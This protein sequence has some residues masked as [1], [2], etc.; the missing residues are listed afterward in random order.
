MRNLFQLLWK[1]HF[2]ILFLFFETAAGYL[3]VQN[4]NF[5]KAGFV[6]SSNTV[7]ASILSVVNDVAEYI[8]LKSTNAFLAEENAKLHALLPVALYN[9][10]NN[11]N[12]VKDTLHKQQ[13]EYIAAKV[14]N[15][16]TNKRNNYLTLNKG[17]LQGIEPEMGVICS[18][19]I[20]GIVKDVSEHYCTVMSLLHK[21]FHTSGKLTR[22]NYFGNLEWHGGNPTE[23]VIVEMPKHVPLTIGD[24]VV[25]TAYSTIFPEG[26][27][28][29]RIKNFD[30]KTG[31]NFYTIDVKLSTDFQNIDYVYIV[32]NLFREEQKQLEKNLHND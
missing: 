27:R 21:D 32:K 22:N 26:I 1:Y 8:H 6:N 2:F 4:N 16:S 29:G 31:N 19:G 24:T 5:Q 28:I 12:V 7:V 9:D 30:L 17:Q 15:N 18:S 23:A 13:Y 11:I 14:I 10:T 20:V 25:T 3:I